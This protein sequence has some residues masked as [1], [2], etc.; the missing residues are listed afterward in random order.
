MEFLAA[1]ILCVVVGGG[2]GREPVPVAQWV[3]PSAVGRP[4]CL[5]A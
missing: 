2:E 1:L 3:K 5:L 4:Q